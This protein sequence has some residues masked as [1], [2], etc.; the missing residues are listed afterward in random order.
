M[1]IY[2]TRCGEPLDTFELHDLEAPFDTYD[3][4]R[5]AF[6]NP[7]Q[8]CGMLFTGKPCEARDTPQ[9]EASLLLAEMLGD[10]VDAIAS[11][12]DSL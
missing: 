4:A 1:D 7:Q 2:C 3:K 12:S 11:M 10:D 9:G 6:F 8:G 5:K